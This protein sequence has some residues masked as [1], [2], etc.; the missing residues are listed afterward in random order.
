MPHGLFVYLQELRLDAAR[1]R[2]AHLFGRKGE[3]SGSAGGA[4][5]DDVER[6]DVSRFERERRAF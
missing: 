3:L 6:A 1:Y 5:D 2:F 4:E